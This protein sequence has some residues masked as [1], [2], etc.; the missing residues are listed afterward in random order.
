MPH[1]VTS[2]PNPEQIEAV[3][4]AYDD[5]WRARDW[6]RDG[7]IAGGMLREVEMTRIM[8]KMSPRKRQ[9]RSDNAEI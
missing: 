1:P 6:I 3:R 4:I 2:S 8:P 9:S 7:L 5:W